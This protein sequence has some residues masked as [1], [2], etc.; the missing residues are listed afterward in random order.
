MPGHTIW[1]A[2]GVHR[3]VVVSADRLGGMPYR[4]FQIVPI[5]TTSTMLMHATMVWLP[6]YHGRVRSTRVLSIPTVEHVLVRSVPVVLL[7]HK[8]RTR[9]F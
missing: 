6:W 2:D 3:L 7:C 8:V 9:T 5:G 4:Y 1:Y